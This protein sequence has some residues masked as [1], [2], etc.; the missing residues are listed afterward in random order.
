MKREP[1]VES[2]TSSDLLPG[3]FDARRVMLSAGRKKA[4]SS[5]LYT[6][7]YGLIKTMGLKLTDGRDFNEARNDKEQNSLIINESAAKL[8]GFQNASNQP[9]EF[10]FGE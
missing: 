10:Y 2:I 1:G 7:D 9:V 3:C 6:V 4:L 5:L 8:L